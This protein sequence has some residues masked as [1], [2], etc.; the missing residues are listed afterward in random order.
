MKRDNKVKNNLSYNKNINEN[1]NVSLDIMKK[2][3]ILNDKDNELDDKVDKL[4]IKKIYQI[5][6]NQNQIINLIIKKSNHI[7][8]KIK[9]SKIDN[10]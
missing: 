4:E 3:I 1:D 10:K 8:N 2:N 5:I 6:K 7:K 9:K